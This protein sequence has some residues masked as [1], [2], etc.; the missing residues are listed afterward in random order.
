MLQHIP[1]GFLLAVSSTDDLL[2][3]LTEERQQYYS[4]GVLARVSAM[5]GPPRPLQE[6]VFHGD[7]SSDGGQIMIR[8][9]GCQFPMGQRFGGPCDRVSPDGKHIAGGDSNTRSLIIRS[10]DGDEVRRFDA[11]YVFGSAW[12]GDGR[13]VWFSASEN[14]SG[15]DLALYAVTLTGDR[16]LI[17]RTPDPLTIQDV[18][19]DGR[20]ALIVTGAGLWNINAA[21]QGP[22]K[23]RPLDHL[24]RTEARGLSADGKWVLMNEVREEG[25]GTFVRST[26]GVQTIQLGNEIGRGLSPNGAWALVQTRDEEP[27]L[28]L[29]PVGAGKERDL[30]L[31][32]ELSALKD[33]IARW[34]H[35]GRRLF[36]PLRTKKDGSVRVYMSEDAGPFNAVTGEIARQPLGHFVVSPSGQTVAAQDRNYVVTLYPVDGRA[37]RALEGERGR[38]VHWSADERELFLVPDPGYSFR[39]RIYRRELASSRSQ[40]WRTLAPDDLTGVIIIQ[41]IFFADDGIS[42]VYQY[43]R[44]SSELFLTYNLR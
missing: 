43:S 3:L 7:W 11:G 19:S 17:A 4:S 22:P 13:E 21:I 41:R 20:S 32:Q 10:A 33:Y 31:D 30:A 35:D 24:G 9:R 29:V 2:V 15:H 28:K 5:R 27:R 6:N 39:A 23:E 36:V 42:Y 14:T 1:P 26:D 38:P 34:S 16:R 12:S 40:L 44:K 8:S 25:L 37:P 18:S